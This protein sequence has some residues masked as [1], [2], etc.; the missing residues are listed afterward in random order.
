MRV[1]NQ[2]SIGIGESNKK[3]F[4]FVDT[5]KLRNKRLVVRVSCGNVQDHF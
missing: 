2:Q 3:D 5:D 1:E 4:W